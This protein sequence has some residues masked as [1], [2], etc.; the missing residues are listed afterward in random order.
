MHVCVHLQTKKVLRK[1]AS[2]YCSHQLYWCCLHI[3]CLLYVSSTWL[4]L[5]TLG[6]RLTLTPCRPEISGSYDWGPNSEK[7]T[8]NRLRFQDH[9]R[10]P[11]SDADSK[12]ICISI[13]YNNG[14]FISASLHVT[15]PLA[16]WN[17]PTCLCLRGWLTSQSTCC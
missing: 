14:W 13:H 16:P 12:A 17:S 9:T 15:Q 5:K 4:Y 2:Y 8:A 6:C 7:L 11:Y 1:E 3:L 10:P